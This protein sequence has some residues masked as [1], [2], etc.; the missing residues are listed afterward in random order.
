MLIHVVD[1][2]N[3]NYKEQ[4]EVTKETLKEIGVD[5]IPIIYA[6]NK[7]DLIGDESILKV[8]ENGVFISAKKK[9]GIEELI[10]K[11]KQE[12]FTKYITCELLIPYDKGNIIAY[13]NDNANIKATT[14]ENDGI[15]IAL[16]CQQSDYA[17][18]EKYAAF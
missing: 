4:I 3:P 5:N 6:Y 16:E 13:L 18:Y 10:T 1:Y 7:I 12:I 15:L 17:R 8:E 9:I 11:I 14:Y 2:S